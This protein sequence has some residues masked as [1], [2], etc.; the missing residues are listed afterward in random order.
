MGAP[1]AMKYDIE[2]YFAGYDGYREL[3]SNSNLLEYQT[4]R[5]NIKYKNEKGEKLYPH[6]ISA[7]GITER[8]VL[9][10]I[11]NNQNADGSINVPKVLQ[12]YMGGIE[13]IEK[14]GK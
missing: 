4:R 8:A 5:L 1:G 7:T 12:S 14:V 3:T 6:T 13:R 9:A 11:E 2:G 10:I